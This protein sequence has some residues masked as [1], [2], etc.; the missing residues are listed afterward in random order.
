MPYKTSITIY[1]QK[2]HIFQP[3]VG[4]LSTSTEQIHCGLGL[5]QGFI[6]QKP[7]GSSC[8]IKITI[9]LL[10]ASLAK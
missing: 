9:Q 5:W 2:W 7:Q 4:P 8:L 1:Q 6:F 10:Q 3:G